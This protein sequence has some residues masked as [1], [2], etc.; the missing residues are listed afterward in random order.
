MGSSNRSLSLEVEQSREYGN[1]KVGD[2]GVVW[3]ISR[4][5]VGRRVNLFKEARFVSLCGALLK[6][7]TVR[8][9]IKDLTMLSESSTC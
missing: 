2:T 5:A 9:S 7:Q 3:K 6:N 4:S 1:L 8:W